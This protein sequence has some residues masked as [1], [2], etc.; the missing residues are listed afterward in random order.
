MSQQTFAVWKSEVREPVVARVAIAGDFLPDGNLELS[1][2]DG[3]REVAEA[4]APYF[5]DVATSFVNLECPIDTDGLT[6]RKLTGLGDIVS[7]P[8]AAIDYLGAIRSA[9]VGF[10]NNHAYDFGAAGVERTRRALAKGKL[11]LIG[12][13]DGATD[14]PDVY[15][16]KGPG[17]V[18]VGLWAAARACHDL[19]RGNSSGV[20]PATLRR[21]NQALQLMKSQGARF[22]IAL[23]H[24]GVIGTNRAD[25]ADMKLMDAIATG[26][27]DIVAA[28]HSHR[29]SGSKRMEAGRGRPA[30]CFYGLGS[31]LSGYAGCPIEREGLVVIAGLKV[32]GSLASVELRPV[33]LGASGFGEV[34]S[35]EAGRTILSRFQQLSGEIADGSAQKLFYREISQN[36]VKLYVRDVRAAFRSSGLAGLARKTGRVRLRHLRRLAHG[37][38]P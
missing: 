30:F 28:S 14:A 2:A 6:A 20:E 36:I 3:W 21:A 8:P 31:L 10:A 32:D 5:E 24:A 12:A 18:R 19:A 15:V 27:F 37:L 11:I 13:G 4:L 34:P 33:L 23:L 7:A 29:I 38:R 17:N 16:W 25:P 1:R 22:S 35:G 9:A 26:G